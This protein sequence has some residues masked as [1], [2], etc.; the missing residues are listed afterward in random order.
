M[1]LTYAANGG[2]L[3]ITET[4]NALLH[5]LLVDLTDLFMCGCCTDLGDQAGRGSTTDKVARVDLDD[6]MTAPGEGVAVGV[7]DPATS[8]VQV[9]I[10]RQALRRQETDLLKITGAASMLSLTPEFL[11]RDAA[12]SIVI[13]RTAQIATLF[14]AVAT[15]I[16]ATTVDLTVTNI[17]Q[18]MFQLQTARNRP[19]FYCV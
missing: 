12:N 11:A 18:A 3:R 5:I 1:A 9:A 19:P 13:R 8:N 4:A 16:G 14:S 17:Y 10:A 6:P 7:T 2:D 15:T